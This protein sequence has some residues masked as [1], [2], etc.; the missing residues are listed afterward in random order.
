MLLS[1]GRSS[2]REV[3]AVP[4]LWHV[5]HTSRPEQSPVDTA[6]YALGPLDLDG[7]C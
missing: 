7:G 4:A 3:G 6:R 5:S 2:L 1:R